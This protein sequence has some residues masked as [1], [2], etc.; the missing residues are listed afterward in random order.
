MLTVKSLLQQ[1]SISN[2]RIAREVLIHQ[3]ILKINVTCFPQTY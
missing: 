2:K 3:R 1:F